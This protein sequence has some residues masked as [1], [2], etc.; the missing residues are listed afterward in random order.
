MYVHVDILRKGN[1][2]RLDFP[3]VPNCTSVPNIVMTSVLLQLRNE[4][5]VEVV[6]NSDLLTILMDSRVDSSPHQMISSIG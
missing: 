5:G 4:N 1:Y 6:I 3:S 2:V